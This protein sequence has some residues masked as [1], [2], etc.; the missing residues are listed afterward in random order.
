MPSIPLEYQNIVIIIII[1]D[2]DVGTPSDFPL[3]VAC[4]GVGFGT[5]VLCHNINDDFRHGLSAKEE[6]ISVAGGG[7]R[8]LSRTHR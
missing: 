6:L 8:S 2:S 4:V 3:S 5:S 7:A 1:I